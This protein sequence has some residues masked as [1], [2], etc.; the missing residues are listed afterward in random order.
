MGVSMES[1][2][3]NDT[4]KPADIRLLS[5][6]F[7]NRKYLIV[8]DVKRKTILVPIAKNT[9]SSEILQAYFHACLCALVTCMTLR[10]PIV[11]EFCFFFLQTCTLG[12]LFSRIVPT[13]CYQLQDILLKARCHKPSYPLLRMYLLTKKNTPLNTGTSSRNPV[14]MILATDEI[15]DKEYRLFLEALER[16]GELNWDSFQINHLYIQISH[17][18]GE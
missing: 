14:G 6:Q 8:L 1:V 4:I 16:N 9:E 3:K 13:N 10:V 18:I 7:K 15:V 17:E 5:N 12:Q 2:F 11:S